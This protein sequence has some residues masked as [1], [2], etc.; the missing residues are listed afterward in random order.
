M[1]MW[2]AWL[3]VNAHIGN[4]SL[5]DEFGPHK[6]LKQN[7]LLLPWQLYRQRDFNFTGYLC[8]FSSFC[9]FCFVP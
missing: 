7:D 5:L 4:H 6:V 3:I 8:I 9:F 2:V 1:C